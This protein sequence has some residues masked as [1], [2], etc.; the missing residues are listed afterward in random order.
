MKKISY[1][2]NK[3]GESVTFCP[4]G[5]ETL[6]GRRKRVGADCLFC[7]YRKYVDFDNHVV[8]CEYVRKKNK[9]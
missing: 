6:R 3:Y 8:E 5:F 4:N 2:V 1:K 9:T 7:M